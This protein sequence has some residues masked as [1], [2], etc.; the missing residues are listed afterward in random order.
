MSEPEELSLLGGPPLWMKFANCR[1]KRSELFFVKRGGRPD[2]G[3]EV[4]E[5]CPVLDECKQYA[6]DLEIEYGVW[7][8]ENRTPASRRS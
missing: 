7:G 5:G 2:A 3:I 1:D 8:G 4:C 6:D